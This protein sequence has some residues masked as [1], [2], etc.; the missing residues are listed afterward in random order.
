MSLGHFFG[1]GGGGV[2]IADEVHET[3][4]GVEERF[5]LDVEAICG[6]L[7]AGDGRTDQ[8][9]A[10]RKGDDV[11][12]GGIAEKIGMD[13]R[14][15]L[16]INE[17]EFDGIELRRQRAR[18]ERNRRLKPPQKRTYPYGYFALSV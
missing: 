13:L 4:K 17:N 11:G 2:V 1:G 10:V 3:V 18:E 7:V 5:L 9:F 16:A 14:H 12:L 6:S 8:D 15:G